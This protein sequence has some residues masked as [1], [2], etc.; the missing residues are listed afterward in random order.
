MESYIWKN[1]N[2]LSND[3]WNQMKENFI[4]KNCPKEYL[5][6]LHVEKVE[7]RANYKNQKEMV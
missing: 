4:D 6:I 1:G 2:L 5:N 7:Y 3:T